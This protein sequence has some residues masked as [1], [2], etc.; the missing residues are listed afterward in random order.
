MFLAQP[1]DNSAVYRCEASNMM[2]QQPLTAEIS[3]SVQCEQRGF[4]LQ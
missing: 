2:L 3:L 1:E 4:I